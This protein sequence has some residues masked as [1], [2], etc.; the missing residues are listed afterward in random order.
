MDDCLQVLYTYSSFSLR[1]SVIKSKQNRNPKPN[2][3]DEKKRKE[4]L[5]WPKGG[6]ILLS[7]VQFGSVYFKKIDY[8]LQL[9]Q[10]VQEI[11]SFEHIICQSLSYSVKG[12]RMMPRLCVCGLIYEMGVLKGPPSLGHCKELLASEGSQL[13]QVSLAAVNAV[14][15]ADCHFGEACDSLIGLEEYSMRQNLPEGSGN[16]DRDIAL[17]NCLWQWL[18]RGRG[19]VG[20]L[21]EEIWM[22][23]A[24]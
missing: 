5:A 24:R 2:P 12:I 7:S 14:I 4:V 6:K 3:G 11:F 1:I 10:S 18:G 8:P 13:L 9:I 16:D 23:K 21:F 22:W 19:P 20:L 15:N 17:E